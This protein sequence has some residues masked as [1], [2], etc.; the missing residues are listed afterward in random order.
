MTLSV[1]MIFLSGLKAES[2][3][4]EEIPI[5]SKPHD[6][7]SVIDVRDYRRPDILLQKE[8]RPKS[9]SDFGEFLRDT[10]NAYAGIW[11]FCAIYIRQ[12]D[13]LITDPIT[14]WKNITHFQNNEHRDSITWNDGDAFITNWVKHPAFGPSVYLYYRVRG[15]DRLASALG[16][17]LQSALFEY[18]VEGIN[19][20]PS[21]HDL[22]VTPE[23]GIPLEIVLE[24]TSNWLENRDNVF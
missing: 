13:Q 1:P 3:F 6:E 20:P 9:L 21:L 18:A 17:F 11:T 2:R 12:K 8:T 16:G 7:S 15:Y 24:K 14:W 19:R 4:N 22:V 23:A 5:P 10:E